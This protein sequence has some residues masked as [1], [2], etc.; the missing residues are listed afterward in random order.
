MTFPQQTRLL[1]VLAVA[2]LLSGCAV[3]APYVSEFQCNRNRDFGKCTN[4]T[5]AYSEALGG[6]VEPS[7]AEDSHG[8]KKSKGD[9]PA[10][11]TRAREDDAAAKA[12]MN[13][14]KA[15]EYREMAGLIDD[16]ITPVVAPPKVLRSLVVAY[17]TSE[18][19]LYLPRYVYFFVSEGNFVMGDYL[20]VEST[21]SPSVMYPNGQGS[22]L[23]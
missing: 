2:S 1:A 12:N 13:R 21:K 11:E 3:F 15:A 19:T 9:R 23:R 16:P 14:Y 18:K 7:A 20:N 6:D 22:E 10:R 17:A 5:G 8:S 4:V